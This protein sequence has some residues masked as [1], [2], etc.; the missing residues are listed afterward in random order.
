MELLELNCFMDKPGYISLNYAKPENYKSI[1]YL[2]KKLIVRD[3]TKLSLED[4]ICYR[5]IYLYTSISLILGVYTKCLDISFHESH[6]FDITGIKLIGNIKLI[7]PL[8]YIINFDKIKKLYLTNVDDLSKLKP[9][10]LEKLGVKE[11][12]ISTSW[13]CNYLDISNIL[14]S[15]IK[16]LGFCGNSETKIIGNFDDNYSITKIIYEDCYFYCEKLD[17]LVERNKFLQYEK[18]FKHTKGIIS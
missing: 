6:I 15:N 12:S 13:Q 11:L 18:R 9:E 14:E 7:T 3:N 4:N 16:A 8:N 1:T 5:Y 2:N 17:K 10:I